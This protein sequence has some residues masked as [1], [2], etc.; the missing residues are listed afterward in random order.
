MQKRERALDN[1]VI[2]DQ[3]KENISF[4]AKQTDKIEFEYCLPTGYFWHLGQVIL[5]LSASVSSSIKWE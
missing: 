3:G 1:V 2:G 5:F 4:R